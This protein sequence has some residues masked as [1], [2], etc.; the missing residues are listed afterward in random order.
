MTLIDLWNCTSDTFIFIR[1]NDSLYEYCGSQEMAH[2][3]I[4]NMKGTSY[5]MYKNVI[6]VTLED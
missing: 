3:K 5:P 6:E 1:T 2:K 4:L